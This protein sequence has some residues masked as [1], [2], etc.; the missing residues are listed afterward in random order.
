MGQDEETVNFSEVQIFAVN[1]IMFLNNLD[2][3]SSYA[4]SFRLY[5]RISEQYNDKTILDSVKQLVPDKVLKS[6]VENQSL[7]PLLHWF[8]YD[9][10]KWMPKELVCPTCERGPMRIQILQEDSAVVRKTEIHICDKCGSMHLFPRYLRILNIAETRIGRCSEWSILFGALLNSLSIQTRI[11]HDFLD[12][13]WNESLNMKWIHIDST[14]EYP[15]S[16]NHPYYYE[17]N[18]GKKYKYVLAFSANGLEDVTRN[19]TQYWQT[20]QKRRGKKDKLEEFRR[21]YLAM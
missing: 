7:Q 4:S 9:F 16:F 15:V 17:Q 11:V 19:Y 2:Q 10:M 3:L 18:W 12:H 14:L 1:I 8:K 6:R 21:S 20:V 5:K 13:C